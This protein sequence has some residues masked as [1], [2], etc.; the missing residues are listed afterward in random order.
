MVNLVSLSLLCFFR[1]ADNV[2]IVLEIRALSVTHSGAMP[3]VEKAS[4]ADEIPCL[5]N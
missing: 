2:S 3:E 5:S 1:S 4:Y